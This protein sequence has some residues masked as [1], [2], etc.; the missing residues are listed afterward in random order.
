MARTQ[1]I[2][3]DYFPFDIDFFTDLKIRKLI[4]RQGAKSIAVYTL[5]LCQIFR[6]GYWLGYDEELPFII[7]DTLGCEEGFVNN[8]IEQCL[9]IG[10]LDKTYFDTEKILTSKGIQK[11]YKEVCWQAKRKSSI[12]KFPLINSEEMAINSELMQQRKVNER[13]ENEMKENERKENNFSHAPDFENV[14]KWFLKEGWPKQ[15]ADMFY[16][17]YDKTGW[18]TKDG[19]PIENWLSAADV[20]CKRNINQYNK[21]PKKITS[22][23]AEIAFTE[24]NEYF[25]KWEKLI[26][27]IKPINKDLFELLQMFEPVSLKNELLK[28]KVLSN[29]AIEI[30]ENKFFDIFKLHFISHFGNIKIEYEL[31]NL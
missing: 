24:L 15:E 19:M 18:K 30:L 16:G 25:K 5:L 28:L 6:N 4:R 3:L 14:K 26:F 9:L 20:W 8:V 22:Q 1:K 23:N 27:S 12:D 11:R 17:Y 13:K 31:R 21:H 2:G 7:S 10:L 29:S